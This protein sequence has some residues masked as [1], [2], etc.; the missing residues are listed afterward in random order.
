M[1][2][3]PTTGDDSRF[4]LYRLIDNNGWLVAR[5]TKAALL[6]YVERQR[7]FDD[8]YALWLIYPTGRSERVL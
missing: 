2:N 4:R 6:A 3:E 8:S 7:R 1:T 5:G